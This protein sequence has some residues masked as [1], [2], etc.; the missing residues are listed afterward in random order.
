MNTSNGE[1]QLIKIFNKE[2]IKFIREKR[3][4]DLKVKTKLNVFF[5]MLSIGIW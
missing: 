2:G 4:K 3:F 1:K 5:S